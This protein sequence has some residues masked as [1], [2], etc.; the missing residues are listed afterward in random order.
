MSTLLK[1]GDLVIP[2]NILKPWLGAVKG[3]STIAALSASEPMVFG[4]NASMTFTVGEA[5]YVGEGAPKSA[6]NITKSTMETRQ[7]K[8]VVQV[9]ESDE[10]MIADEQHQLGVVQNILAQAQRPLSRALDIMAFHGVDPASG[11]AISIAQDIALDLHNGGLV[12]YDPATKPYIATD[13]AKAIVVANGFTPKDLALTGG[14]A[15][16]F[17]AARSTSTEQPLYSNF[18]LGTELGSAEGLR[19]SVSDTV[20]LYSQGAKTTLGFLGDFSAIRWGVVKSMG[21]KVIE[22]GDPDGQGDLQNLNEVVF[23]AEII[24]AVGVERGGLPIVRIVAA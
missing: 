15:V 7:L 22:Y 12:T 10:V 6:A 11:T 17:S 14:L 19:T 23:R 5:Q 21:L 8:L 4:S 20:A 18:L 16:G 24:Y 9:R 13:A 1:T 3:D 2:Q